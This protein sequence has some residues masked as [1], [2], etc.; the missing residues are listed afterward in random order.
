MHFINTLRLK[1][2]IEAHLDTLINE[3]ASY[4]LTRAG[5]SYIYNSVQQ[6]KPE[7]V[8]LFNVYVEDILHACLLKNFVINVFA[9]EA[10][11][12]SK[13]SVIS[14]DFSHR[15]RTIR[16]DTLQLNISPTLCVQQA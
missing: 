9:N 2:Q 13:S 8:S 12:E 1:F 11:S 7:Q 4:V 5:L 6:H 15:T 3:Q 16:P 14:V 10:A